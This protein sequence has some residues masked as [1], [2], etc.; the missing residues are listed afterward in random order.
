[1]QLSQDVVSMFNDPASSKTVSTVDAQGNTYAAP[2][3]SVRAT[4]DG[5]QLI[6]AYFTA[7][8]TPKRIDYMKQAGKMPVVVVQKKEFK[9]A[10]FEGY[11]VWC[12]IGDTLTSGPLV[13]KVKEQMP[14]PVI[15]RFPVRAVVTLQPVKYKIQGTLPNAGKTVTL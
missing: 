4:P 6:F 3:G 9:K 14:K 10:G 15:E 11:C 1:M 5:S 7:Q 8:E 12:K 13:E 2:F